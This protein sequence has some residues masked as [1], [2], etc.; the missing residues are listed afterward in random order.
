MIGI[1]T[2]LISVGMVFAQDD[3]ATEEP[4]EGATAEAGA[5]TEAQVTE[6]VITLRDAA[7]NP[8]NVVL[9]QVAGGFRSPL[10]MT[11]APDGSGR[12]F[13]LQQTGQ[14]Y[15]LQDG[16]QLPDAFLDLSDRVS[17]DVLSG[18]SERGLLGLA[19]HPNYAEN[20]YF[21]VNYTTRGDGTTHVSRFSVSADDPNVGDAGSESLLLTIPQPYA[22]HNGGQMAFGPD[23]YLYISVGDG[24]SA[25]DPLA[26]G[27]NPSDL[28]GSLL[29]IDVDSEEGEG[30]Y[31]VPDD[32]PSA[33]DANFAPEVWAYG[34]R[35]VWRFSFDRATGDLYIADVGQN[36]WEE[37]NFI[38]AGTPGG[39]NFGW[40]VFEGSMPFAGGTAPEGMIYPIAEYQH[41]E[42]G[43]SITGGYVYRGEQV[44]ELEGVYLFGD[45]CSGRIWASYR[46]GSGSWQTDLFM[47]PQMQISS[48]GE[49]EN[50]E[51]YIVDY[52]GRIFRF[53]SPS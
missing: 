27:Q 10:Y 9:E 4:T 7:P 41:G 40:N 45:Y 49:D 25:N 13:V 6:D 48:F 30:S 51:L 1:L 15:I 43:C 3:A 23:G 2:L 22:N 14:I 5:E 18:Y 38:E 36:R 24:G 31:A 46:D 11:Y 37:V 50:G 21:Y 19:F 32:N 39:M 26:T 52:G 16:E 35:N 47:T 17:Q 34:L 8:S 29:R 53:A 42:N 20:G 44:S 28:L 33:S 12:I